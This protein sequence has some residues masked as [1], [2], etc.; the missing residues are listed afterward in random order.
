MLAVAVGP[1]LRSYMSDLLPEMLNG[2]LNNDLTEALGIMG[3]IIVTKN[4][5]IVRTTYTCNYA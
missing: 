2:G 1:A 5:Y 3:N 4:T